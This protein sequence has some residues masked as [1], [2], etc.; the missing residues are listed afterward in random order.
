MWLLVCGHV[1]PWIVVL[2][3]KLQKVNAMTAPKCSGRVDPAC[4]CDGSCQPGGN[5]QVA[6]ACPACTAHVST[7]FQ[8]LSNFAVTTK[9][10]ARGGSGAGMT[11]FAEQGRQELTGQD[12]AEIPFAVGS[13][14][15]LRQWTLTSPDLAKDPHRADR[16]WPAALLRGATGYDWT[17]GTVEAACN[18]GYQHPSPAEFVDGTEKSRCGCGYW[19]Y[20]DSAGLSANRFS[21]TSN[22]LPVLGVIEGWGRVLI[23]EKGFRSQK[24][25][26]IALAPA[27]SI[28]AEVTPP[29]NRGLYWDEL[30]SNRIQPAVE[31]PAEEEEAQ[32]ALKAQQHADAWM[33]VIQDR[34]GQM[35][36]GARVFA[37]AAGLLA[38][39]KIEGKP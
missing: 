28:Q 23:G 29:R 6:C 35:Y 30:D 2:Y 13:V 32:I 36:P 16:H 37:T 39:V 5:V 27:F 31:E 33:A 9:A 20:W 17:S 7:G 4:A 26:I 18:N 1:I 10:P 19:A 24:A 38:S 11:G 21:A 22:G 15:G 25:R 34:L 14:T 8:P 12:K 3:L